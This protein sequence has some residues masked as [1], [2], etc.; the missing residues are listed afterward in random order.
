MDHVSMCLCSV[1]AVLLVTPYVAVWSMCL[2]VCFIPR[3]QWKC[4]SRASFQVKLFVF[5]SSLLPL[6]FWRAN[7]E[8]FLNISCQLPSNCTVRTPAPPSPSPPPQKQENVLPLL[9]SLFS[10]IFF[11]GFLLFTRTVRCYV[12][13]GADFWWERS[14]QSCQSH[15]HP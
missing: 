2:N 10:W 6:E 3:T 11:H 9:F 1:I 8:R 13:L 12:V 5:F 4:V 14:E 7:R 15:S